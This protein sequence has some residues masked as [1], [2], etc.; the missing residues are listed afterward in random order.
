MRVSRMLPTLKFRILSYDTSIMLKPGPFSF[1]VWFSLTLMLALVNTGMV[2]A[3]ARPTVHHDL[4]VT[5]KPDTHELIARDI[6]TI[7]ST[8]GP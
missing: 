8:R 5:L 3:G 1:V 7:P 6:L 4:E 2:E